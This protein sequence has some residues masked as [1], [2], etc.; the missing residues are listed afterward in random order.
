MLAGGDGTSGGSALSGAGVATVAA[1]DNDGVG[2]GLG[3]GEETLTDVA[4]DVRAGPT[5]DDLVAS[6]GCSV[7]LDWLKF[8][9]RPPTPA[10]RQAGSTQSPMATLP[11]I[12]STLCSGD[13]LAHQLAKA[14][15]RPDD[16]PDGYRG[17]TPGRT[18]PV[19]PGLALSYLDTDGQTA[20]RDHG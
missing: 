9:A 15:E 18:T 3:V 7:W 12:N 8:A 2:N 5:V 11:K 1:D 16:P 20:R 13:T 6:T 14:G 10:T 4:D 19:P 17:G